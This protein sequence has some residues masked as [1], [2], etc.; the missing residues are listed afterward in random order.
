M[1]SNARRGYIEPLGEDGVIVIL[2]SVLLYAEKTFRSVKGVDQIPGVLENI[3]R[4]NQSNAA[5]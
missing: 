3:E 5:N 1:P 4:E 2:A